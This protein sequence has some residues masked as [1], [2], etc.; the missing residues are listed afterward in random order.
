MTVVKLPK[1]TTLPW[2]RLKPMFPT[3]AGRIHLD[4]VRE[5]IS[6]YGNDFVIIV[7]S[8]VLQ[9]GRKVGESCREFVEQVTRLAEKN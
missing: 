4:H 6:L 5:L 2:G 7:G 1:E 8:E 3:A 9:P